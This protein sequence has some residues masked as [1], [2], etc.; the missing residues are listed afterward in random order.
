MEMT[1]V[2]D[3][4]AEGVLQVEDGNHGEYRPRPHEFVTD[5]IPF[6]RAADMTTG[7]VTFATAGRIDTTARARI[8]KGIGRPGDVLLSH[9]GTVGKV[10]V[11]P[12]DAPD[13]VCSPQ[14]TFWRSTDPARIDQRYLPYV[15]QSPSFRAQLNY[16]MGQTDM[17]PYVS[18][19]DQRAMSIP[20]PPIEVQRGIA[21]VLGTLDDK[22]AANARTRDLLLQL[23]DATFARLVSSLPRGKRL[24]DL[25]DITKGVSY[26]SADLDE[27]SDRAMV[28][29]KSITRD[30]RYSPAGLKGYIGVAKAAQTVEPGEVVVAQTDLTQAAEVVGRA[31]RVP[32]SDEFSGLVASLDLAIVRPRAGMPVEFLLGLLRTPQFRQH[33]RD[34]TSGT[35]VLHLGRGAIESFLAPDVD[36]KS[37]QEYAEFARPVFGLIDSTGRENDRLGATRDALLPQLM[38]GKIRVKDAGRV[39][40]VG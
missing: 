36:D 24:A 12:L 21:E 3:L 22:I 13:Y 25:A 27:L 35:T 37:Q 23:A 2:S 15:L 7:V 26:R 38:S 14:T 11:A 19:T 1:L 32:A 28:T 5:G 33:C 9:K 6:I 30:G 4:V 39:E 17:A 8:R 20:V 29:L 16:L 34:R 18:L 10:A 40:G 31:V